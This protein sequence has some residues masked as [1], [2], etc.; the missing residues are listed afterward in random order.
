MLIKPSRNLSPKILALI[1][2]TTSCTT[3]VEPEPSAPVTVSAKDTWAFEPEPDTY[4]NQALLDLRDLNETVA[5]ESGFIRLSP[6]GRDFVKGDGSPIRFW[7]V[8]S[9]IWRKG[10]EEIA[11][12]ARFLAKRGVPMA[13][14]ATSVLLGGLAI[15]H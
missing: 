5:G 7:A 3:S 13:P 6:D 10:Q 12:Q 1:L 8:N 9:Y 15:Y 14:T 4:N 2:L 11:D